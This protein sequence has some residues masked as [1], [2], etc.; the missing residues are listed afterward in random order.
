M[1]NDTKT[2][3]RILDAKFPIEEPI[4]A[5]N[6]GQTALMFAASAGQPEVL[7]VLLDK[8]ANLKLSD[9]VGR[10]ALHYCCRGGNVQNLRVL[11][12]AYNALEGEP[13]E[14]FEKRSNGGLTPLMDAI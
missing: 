14:H 8:G 6:G 12:D 5:Y 10:T 1:S 3:K 4:Q 2:L 9:R 7:Q 13:T 11:L